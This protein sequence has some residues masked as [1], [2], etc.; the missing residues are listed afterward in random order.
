MDVALNDCTEYIGQPVAL[1]MSSAQLAGYT[2]GHSVLSGAKPN[3]EREEMQELFWLP[4]V[5]K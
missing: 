3:T 5:T 4:Q 2:K 1:Y